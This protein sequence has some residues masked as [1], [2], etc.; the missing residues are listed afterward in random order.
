MERP[1]DRKGRH[2]ELHESLDELLA[3]FIESTG[4]MPSDTTLMEFLEWSAKKATDG[5]KTGG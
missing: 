4:K 3:C 5:N 2:Q 1:C